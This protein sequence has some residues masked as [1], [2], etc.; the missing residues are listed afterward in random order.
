MPSKTATIPEFSGNVI[1]L[2]AAVV[3]RL[4]QIAEGE[5]KLAEVPLTL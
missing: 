3:I 2:T 1:Y 4:V 5:R